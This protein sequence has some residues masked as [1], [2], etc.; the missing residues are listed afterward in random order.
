MS[1][2]SKIELEITD[3]TA[4]KMACKEMGLEFIEN[5]TTYKWYGRLV[6]SQD[7]PLP[8]GLTEKDLGKCT[9]AIS[10]PNAEY[11]LGVLRYKGKYIILCDW[12]DSK[13]KL[14]IGKDANL[15]KQNYTVQRIKAEA[16]K[17]RFRFNKQH[18]KEGGIKITLTQAA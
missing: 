9:H 5:Q 13:L 8:E 17:Q 3:L 11:E 15:L 14:K 12:W 10:V 16:R 6:N 2:V 4:L 7:T 18:T 1:H